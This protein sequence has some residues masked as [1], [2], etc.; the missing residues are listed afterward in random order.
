MVKIIDTEKKILEAAKQEFVKKGLNGARMQGIAD[1]AGINKALLHY[2]FRTKDRLFYAIFQEAFATLIPYVADI[3]NLEIPLEVKLNRL[4]E[5][6]IEVLETNPYLPL[7]VLSEIQHN[8]GQ[9]KQLLNL[10]GFVDIKKLTDQ[11]KQEFGFESINEKIII[12]LF[13]SFLAGIIFPFIG[14][15]IIQ[16][17]MK[18]SESEFHEFLEERK[19]LVPYLFIENIKSMN[20]YAFNKN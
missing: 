7:F 13:I 2:Y 16:F 5:K 18:M 3:F 12:H 14:R 10:H 17:N 1:R 8:P 4:S 9:V 20:N 19:R 11:I 15:P 6:Y